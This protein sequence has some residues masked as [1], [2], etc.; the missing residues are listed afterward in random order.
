[1]P[2]FPYD[3]GEYLSK[4]MNYPDSARKYNI[5]GRVVASFIVL[6]D[7]SLDSIK[8]VKGIGGGCDEEVIRI[9]ESMP[10]W[11]PGKHN[12]KI[13]KVRVNMPIIFKLED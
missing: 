4:N 6:K 5:E 13:V 3:L 7:G 9:I 10:K 8:I 12:G 11:K 2:S 1:M